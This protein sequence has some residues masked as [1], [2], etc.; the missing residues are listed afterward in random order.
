MAKDTSAVEIPAELRPVIAAAAKNLASHLWGPG[1]PPWG[2]SFDEV[3]SLTALISRQLGSQLLQQALQRQADQPLPSELQSCPACAGPLDERPPEP[4]SVR[5]GTGI[6]DW[7]EPARY[8]P[9]CRRAFFPSEQ[10][11]GPRPD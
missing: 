7:Q 3:E 1:G 2:T 9:R 8:C 6:T 4:R 11:P 10:E 5:T